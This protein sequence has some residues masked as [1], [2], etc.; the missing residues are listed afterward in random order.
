MAQDRVLNFSLTLACAF[1]L[2]SCNAAE[3]QDGYPDAQEADKVAAAQQTATT[4]SSCTAIAPFYWEIG[5][6]DSILASGATGDGSVTRTTNMLIGSASKWLFGAY[7]IQT[8]GGP[9]TTQ[10]IPY[11]TMQAGYTDFALAAQTPRPSPIASTLRMENRTGIST[12]N[13]TRA[14]SASS[15]TTAATSKLGV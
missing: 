8:R 10:D 3:P 9:P 11:L 2:A 6:V 13:T 7:V 4:N 14:T 12:L 15:F 5:N 1:A